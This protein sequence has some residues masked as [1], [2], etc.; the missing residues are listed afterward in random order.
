MILHEIKRRRPLLRKLTLT[1]LD[2]L[3]ILFFCGMISCTQES[4]KEPPITGPM[5][6]IPSGEFTMGTGD[7][8]QKI[9]LP[10]YFIDKTEVTNEMFEKFILAGGYEKEEYWTEAG[11]NFIKENNII[12]HKGLSQD[13]FN[14]PNQPVTGISWYEADA[15]C[16]WAGKRLP[17]AEEWEKAARGTDGRIYPWGN[18]M[19]F[20]RLAYRSSNVHRTVDVG[21][22]P[23]GASPYGVLDMAGNVW[24]WTASA[25]NGVDYKYT[26]LAGRKAEKRS[27][28]MIIKGGAW[29]SN[30]N[31]F[32]CGYQYYDR[33]EA[34]QFNIGFRCVSDVA[35]SQE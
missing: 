29:G 32:Q 27:E 5:I 13:S 33:K 2:I 6:E 20:S 21:S 8:I 25:Y 28:L 7:Q 26:I 19:D 9:S 17:T 12:H 34:T 14:E 30:R 1:Q 11:W 10:T 23:D 18:R 3:L 16:R 35:Q 31:Q 15:F 22:F 4:P 24:E